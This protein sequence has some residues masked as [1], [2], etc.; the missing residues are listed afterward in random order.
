MS[1]PRD[2]ISP[3]LG[4][5]PDFGFAGHLGRTCNEGS[6]D[7]RPSRSAFADDR[8]GRP[9]SIYSQS[10]VLSAL[11]APGGSWL[12]FEWVG[13]FVVR[14]SPGFGPAFRCHPARGKL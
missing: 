1:S 9:V 5:R 10:Y 6:R 11:S 12:T 7:E 4:N 14:C 13:A 8:K 2:E 3:V